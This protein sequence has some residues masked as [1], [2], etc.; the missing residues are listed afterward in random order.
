MAKIMVVDNDPSIATMIERILEAEGYEVSTAM[1]GTEC[2][3]ELEKEK[4]DLLLLDVMM[5]DLS[6]WDVYWRIRKKDE[7]LK[8]AFVSVVEVSP[9]RREELIRDYGISDYIIK[10]FTHDGLTSA[11][12]QI[13]GKSPQKGSK[14]EPWLRE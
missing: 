4:P 13:L 1:S 12:K 11:V 6:G 8:V 9:G 14:S 10:P 7:V 3:K 5:P 2:L